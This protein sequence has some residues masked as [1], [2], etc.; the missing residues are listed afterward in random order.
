MWKQ[1]LINVG[2]VTADQASDGGFSGTLIPTLIAQVYVYRGDS[3]CP[4]R[5]QRTAVELRHMEA[6]D[7]ASPGK[8]AGGKGR[9]RGIELQASNHGASLMS[10]L[11]LLRQVFAVAK[12]KSG[13]PHV[14]LPLASF[15]SIDF[16]W[17]SCHAFT[18][19]L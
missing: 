6:T 10:G 2:I 15:V 9:S 4:Q 11:W 3:W 14:N 5:M 17:R 16:G 8:A 13:V 18:A 12:L 19:M 7:V 1:S